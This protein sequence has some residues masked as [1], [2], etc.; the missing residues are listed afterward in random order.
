MMISYIENTFTNNKHRRWLIRWINT[1]QM[2]TEER[3]R[4]KEKKSHQKLHCSAQ[5]F[6]AR[7]D[8]LHKYDIAN[9][10]IFF[11]SLRLDSDSKKGFNCEW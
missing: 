6:W 7:N 8:F 5:S 10:N 9:E 1:E 11:C 4:K 2:L 3:R